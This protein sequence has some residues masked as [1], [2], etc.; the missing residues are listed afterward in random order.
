M[1]DF[2]H[3]SADDVGVSEVARD[4]R[5][6]K[7]GG[8]VCRIVSLLRAVYGKSEILHPKSKS[9]IIHPEPS[10]SDAVT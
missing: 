7:H 5:A 2:V 10:H 9:E 6:S 3:E 1:G 4:H 8:T